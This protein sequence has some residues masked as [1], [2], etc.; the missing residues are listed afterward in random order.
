MRPAAPHGYIAQAGYSYRGNA[1]TG[2]G[3]P[4]GRSRKYSP[5]RVDRSGA[6][7]VGVV[8][9]AVALLLLLLLPLLV[10]TYLYAASEQS[11]PYAIPT[12]GNA[13][14]CAATRNPQNPGGSAGRDRGCSEP[15]TEAGGW[16]CVSARSI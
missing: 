16:G 2:S 6:C 4:L 7:V 8:V 11:S 15:G 5:D 10:G 14:A 9:V 3:L 1:D 13:T 12:S